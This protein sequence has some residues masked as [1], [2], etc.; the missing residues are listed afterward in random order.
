MRWMRCV[1]M[2]AI[3]LL[4]ALLVREY[5]HAPSEIANA[6][7]LFIPQGSIDPER[8]DDVRLDRESNSTSNAV[9]RHGGKQNQLSIP[10]MDGLCD[11]LFRAC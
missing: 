4:L 2:I 3:A 7:H 9:E 11:R 8:V 10:W 6:P 1:V 5:S